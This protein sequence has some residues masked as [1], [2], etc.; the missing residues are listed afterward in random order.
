MMSVTVRVKLSALMFLQDFV[1][2]AWSVTLGTWLG[3]TLG[4]PASRSGWWPAPRLAAMI[5]P[6]FVGMIGDLSRSC[7]KPRTRLTNH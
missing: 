7:L 6:F 5:S 2:A 3:Q 4:F 1:W